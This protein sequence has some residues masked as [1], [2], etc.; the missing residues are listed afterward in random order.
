M[1][2]I[3]QKRLPPPP[4]PPKTEGVALCAFSVLISI[5]VVVGN[6][7]TIL[8][9][10][11]NKRLS[12]QNLFPVINMAFADLM[13]GAVTLPIYINILGASYKDL[14]VCNCS[15]FAVLAPR[16]LLSSTSS[17]SSER[18]ITDF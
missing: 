8:L 14:A 5:F 4:H 3:H 13:L 15:C 18:V 1:R 11:V 17:S 6:F 16:P 12:K 2:L 9:V 10:A 7:V